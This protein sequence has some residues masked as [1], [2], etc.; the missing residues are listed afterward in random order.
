MFSI[1]NG[2][3]SR[4][5]PPT[6]LPPPCGCRAEVPSLLLLVSNNRELSRE[7]MYVVW[8]HTKGCMVKI[9]SRTKQSLNSTEYSSIFETITHRGEK[10]DLMANLLIL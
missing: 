8:P 6:L 3:S 4:E 10:M 5:G 1:V 2:G 7:C 9:H